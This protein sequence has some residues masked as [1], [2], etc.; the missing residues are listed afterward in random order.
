[1]QIRLKGYITIRFLYFMAKLLSPGLLSSIDW[2][3]PYVTDENVTR[4]TR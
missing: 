2:S 3:L 4:D 1:M